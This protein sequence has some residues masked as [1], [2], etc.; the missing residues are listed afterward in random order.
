MINLL[1]STITFSSKTPFEA[2]NR[3]KLQLH[4]DKE[5]GIGKYLGLTEHFG[6]RKRDIIASIVDRIRQRSHSWTASFL[7]GA[8]K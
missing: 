2:R 5:G 7:S 6:R 8:G 4:I 3:V 1:K